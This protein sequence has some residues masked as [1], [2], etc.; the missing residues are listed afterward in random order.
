[1]QAIDIS[2][3]LDPVNDGITVIETEYKR[4]DE[5]T[6]VIGTNGKSRIVDVQ[7]AMAIIDGLADVGAGEILGK[8][9][10]IAMYNSKTVLKYDTGKCFIGSALIMKCSKDGLSFLAGTEF[11]EAAK[12]FTS[13][14]ITIVG[15]G[16]E[17]SA[18][19]LM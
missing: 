19:E 11:E 18:Y 17:F 1:M 12:E 3:Q 9:D 2:I 10:Y 14:L 8:T 16:D 6:L 7:E 15:N 4:K 13:R 5:G